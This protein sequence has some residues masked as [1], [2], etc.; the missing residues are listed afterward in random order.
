MLMSI[1]LSGSAALYPA[2]TAC[3]P[4]SASQLG[5][6][7]DP[8]GEVI[9]IINTSDVSYNR[10]AKGVYCTGN[11][12]GILTSFLSAS[13]NDTARIVARDA[14]EEFCT[15]SPTCKFCSVDC[16]GHGSSPPCRW[17]AIPTCG[18]LKT[19]PGLIV[20]DVSQKLGG[21]RHCLRY[22]G[23][24]TL[25]LE[26]CD[27]SD[28][29]RFLRVGSAFATSDGKSCLHV[30]AASATGPARVDLS[31][32]TA[33]ST[34][35]QFTFVAPP[36][37]S[38][39]PLLHLQVGDGRCVEAQRTDPPMSMSR[40]RVFPSPEMA[41]APMLMSRSRVFPSPEMVSSMRT[42]S[43]PASAVI[44][45]GVVFN[46]TDGNPLHAHGAGMLLPAAHPG[47]ASYARL[48]TP[49]SAQLAFCHLRTPISA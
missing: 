39:P 33:A 36:S 2:G 3:N 26:A 15:T 4:S 1:G 14:C 17:N 25:E 42:A 32:C 28:A 5:W 38:S 27:G 29:Q 45:S 24:P 13:A 6:N 35:Q 16:L 41:S 49:N 43:S 7:F 46:D 8:L 9:S 21:A 22:A 19:W 47:G 23:A 18:D 10:S 12:V 11:K 40:S 48:Q 30:E 37:S 34:S 31:K 20:G 44:T